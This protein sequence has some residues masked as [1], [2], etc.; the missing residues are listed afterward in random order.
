MSFKFFVI[1]FHTIYSFKRQTYDNM[2]IINICR[3]L[4]EVRD[5]GM[6]TAAFRII[7]YKELIC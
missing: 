5:V 2:K 3:I 7:P 1:K 6:E 4:K